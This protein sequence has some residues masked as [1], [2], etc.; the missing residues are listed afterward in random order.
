MNIQNVCQLIILIVYDIWDH[1]YV[2]V[3]NPLLSD[4]NYNRN[5]IL[6][7]IRLQPLRTGGI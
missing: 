2:L 3:S 6:L 4:Q 1:H 7:L 5:A